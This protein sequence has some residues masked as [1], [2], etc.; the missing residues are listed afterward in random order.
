MSNL[1]TLLTR[2]QSTLHRTRSAIHTIA[3]RTVPRFTFL[4][5]TSL[6]SIAATFT[7]LAA[8]AQTAAQR[9][10]CAAVDRDRLDARSVFKYGL[11]GEELQVQF[12]GDKDDPD[13]GSYNDDDYRPVRLTGYM[14]NGNVRYATKWAKI[15]GPKW[16]SRAGLTGEQFDARFNA[17]RATHRIVDI[18][19]YNTPDGPRYADIW[20]ENSAG[21]KWAVK[22]RTP[23]AQMNAVKADMQSKGLAPTRIEGYM[24][25]DSVHFATVWTEAP[26]NCQW[27]LEFNLSGGDY[28]TLVSSY[29][30]DTR[31]IH[32]DSYHD[33]SIA[34]YAGIWWDQSGPTLSASHGGHWYTF[35]RL[36]NNRSCEGFV[37][38]NFYVDEAPSGWNYMGGIWGYRGPPNVS[39]TSSLDTR[40]THHINCADGRAGA[41]IV[42]LDT[43]ETAMAHADQWF[44]SASAIKAYVFFTLLRKADAEGIDLTTETYDGTTLI[45]L[46][47]TMIRDSNNADTNT[48]IDYL[49]RDRINEEIHETLGLEVTRLDRYMSGG[50]SAHGLGSWFDDFKAGYD[51]FVTPREFVTFYQK[52]WENDGL[53]SNSARTTFFDITDMPNTIMN[54]V[55]NTEVA[56]FDPSFVQIN[57]KPGGKSY[58]GDPGDF[59]HKPQLGDHQITSDA[60]IMQFSNGQVVFF[61]VIVDDADLDG[62]YRSISCTGWEVGKEYSGIPVGNPADCAYP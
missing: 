32:V 1:K 53:L 8:Q 40:V 60:G 10:T 34:R 29:W 11:S 30:E 19:A 3:E 36:L 28:Q 21:I 22:R 23:Q 51:N 45:S 39:D 17:L 12:F 48:L 7:P 38:D 44:S 62:A 43:G 4:A 33:G 25:D 52:V 24:L 41:A 47:T 26:R 27:D 61:A 58:T 59:T 50:P 54:D 13:D 2:T 37:L 46:A 56:G 42:N 35:Q 14:D 18:S 6:A 16:Q 55:L 57:N 5:F 9:D 20:E 31:L 15:S 49:T